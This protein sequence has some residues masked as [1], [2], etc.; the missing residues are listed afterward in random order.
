L[1]VRGASAGG[2]L[3]G[4]VANRA[5]TA[6]RAVVAEVPFVDVVT[7]MLDD[8]LP[9]TVGEWDEWGDPH[10]PEHYAYM[11]SYS[12]YDNLPGTRRPA[13]MVTASRH[14]PR[15]SVHEP[16]KW[17]A[18]MRLADEAAGDVESRPLLLQTAM[19]AGAHT[20]PAGRYDAWRHEASMHAFVIDMLTPEN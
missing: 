18:K 14:D 13:L 7:T 3:M 20:G 11:L 12:P 2:L 19:G 15:V 6:M 8:S 1:A 9:L 16:A 4:A 17:V 5:P 10:Q